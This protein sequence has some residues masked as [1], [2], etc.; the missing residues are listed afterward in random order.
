MRKFAEV[1]LDLIDE[2]ELPMRETMDD[3]R[4]AQ[5]ADS[6]R[7]LGVIQPLRLRPKDGGRFEIVSGHRRFMASRMVGLAT[8]PAVMHTNDSTLVAAR[9]A[10]NL[11]REDVNPKEEAV[12]FVQLYSELGEDVD[13]VVTLAGR[14]RQYIEERMN[15]LRGDPVVLE[16]LGRGDITLGLATELNRFKS[17][18]SRRYHLDFAMRSGATVRQM[19]EWRAQANARDELAAL[20]PPQTDASGQPLPAPGPTTEHGNYAAMAKPWELSGGKDMRECLFCSEAH[21]EYKM[22][23]QYV[24]ESCAE[25]HVM[26]IMQKRGG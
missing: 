23:R 16:A 13:R 9:V 15:L 18:S 12:Y 4:L 25:R 11:D 24:C 5:L 26:P 10:E 3:A 21:P 8:V 14:P 19:R 2:P 7:M 17:E 20:A 22:F 6:I 1:A